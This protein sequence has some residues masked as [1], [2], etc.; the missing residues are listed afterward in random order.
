MVPLRVGG[1]AEHNHLGV[2]P[3]G[4]RWGE[5]KSGALAFDQQIGGAFVHPVPEVLSDEQEPDFVSGLEPVR[6]LRGGTLPADLEIERVPGREVEG[7]RVG[8]REGHRRLDT[9]EREVPRVHLY[10]EVVRAAARAAHAIGRVAPERCVEIEAVRMIEPPWHRVVHHPTEDRMVRIVVQHAARE[11]R[12]EKARHV[13]LRLRLEA[14]RVREID[15]RHDLGGALDRAGD[16]RPGGSG[17]RLGHGAEDRRGG[18]R[19]DRFVV[20]SGRCGST[21]LSRMLDV[22]PDV[23][24]LFEFFNGLDFE[25]RFAPEPISGAAFAELVSREQPMAT[26]V[27]RRGYRVEEIVYPFAVEGEPGGGRYAEGDALPWILVALLPR[28]SDAPDALFRAAVPAG[29][30]LA[31][32]SRH[33]HVSTFILV[34]DN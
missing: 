19:V 20:G 18:E 3:I 31:D 9:P 33:L 12:G 14:G 16:R 17:E 1:R 23:S 5:R 22:H 29:G 25:R 27:L 15:L 8:R 28:L 21:L 34:I 32:L 11:P 7:A 13:A 2:D 6:G 10:V 26:A 4:C 30:W 24:S